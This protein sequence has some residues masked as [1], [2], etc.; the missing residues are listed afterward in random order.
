MKQVGHADQVH[1]VVNHFKFLYLNSHIIYNTAL[2]GEDLE[3]ME[4][5]G[6]W[7]F[8]ECRHC[9]F[10]DNRDPKAPKTWFAKRHVECE[11]CLTVIIKHGMDIYDHALNG[12]KDKQLG[13][14]GVKPTDCHPGDEAA[15]MAAM[16]LIKLGGSPD[17]IDENFAKDGEKRDLLFQERHGHR[18]FI[19]AAALLEYAHSKSPANPQVLLLLV[20][21]YTS[22]GAGSLAMR[23]Y[24]RLNLKQIQNE[25]L[26]YIL[27]DRIS[28]MHP[29]ACADIMTH[30][31]PVP[32]DPATELA[33]LHVN[34]KRFKEQ[35]ER[36]YWTCL[37]KGNYGSVFQ[38]MDVNEKL[39]PSLA[40]AMSVVER[41]KL[42]RMTG[43]DTDFTKSSHGYEI[44]RKSPALNTCVAGDILTSQ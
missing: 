11:N 35:I 15:I 7:D 5:M 2:S 39:A 22:L 16:A 27:L 33:K 32:F 4:D 40:G 17:R 30:E 3:E 29:H 44:L 34:Y 13:P 1:A 28:S 37:E 21:I 43:L 12:W 26:G 9:R 10:I 24:V 14:L 41:R 25:T 42:L 36:N 19:Q 23:A 31:D 18:R 20:K 38:L 6:E 8:F